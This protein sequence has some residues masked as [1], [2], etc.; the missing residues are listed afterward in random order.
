MFNYEMPQE[1]GNRTETRW[2]KVTNESGVGIKATLQRGQGGNAATENV[3]T[4]D[5]GWAEQPSSPLDDWEIIHQPVEQL[6]EKKT[7]FDFAVSKYMAADLDQ[8]QHPYELK[9]SEGVCFRI[10]DEH[11]GLGS[12]SCGPDTLEPYRLKM[13]TFDFTVTLE[14]TGM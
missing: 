11:H 13:K 9:G 8:A 4:I 7:V 5:N 6:V 10:D 1:N 14:A 2:V 3:K 12:A